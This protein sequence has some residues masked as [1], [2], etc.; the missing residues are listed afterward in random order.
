VFAASPAVVA[1]TCKVCGAVPVEGETAN[2]AASLVTEKL[3]DPPPLFV[4]FS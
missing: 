2:Q 1:E 4:T 3:N